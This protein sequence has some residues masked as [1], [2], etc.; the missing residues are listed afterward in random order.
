VKDRLP[1]VLS[2]TALVVAVLGVTP[3]GQATSTAIQTHF[4]RNANFLRG[5]APSIK[6]GKNKI[7]VA[8][9]AGKLDRS[10]GAVGARGPAGPPGAN[11][12]P[13]PAGAPG[14]PGPPGPTGTPDTSNFYNKAESDAR[15]SPR[16]CCAVSGQVMSGQISEHYAANEGFW[17]GQGTFSDPLPVGAAIPTLEYRSGGTPSATCPGI[18][19]ATAGRL[20]VYGFNASNVASISYGGNISGGSHRFGFGFDI[21]PTN[22][23]AAGYLIANWAYRVP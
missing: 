19:Q 4:A 16:N 2:A 6:A 9:K 21:F 8:N 20:C 15:F 14:P 18:G 13:G 17:L 5:K 23:A 1:V 3:V 11:G 10:W 22:G 12:A 7:P